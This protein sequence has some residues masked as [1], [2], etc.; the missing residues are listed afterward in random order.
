MYHPINEPNQKKSCL[1]VYIS[2]T[3][4]INLVISIAALAFGIYIGVKNKSVWSNSSFDWNKTL[5]ALLIAG[6]V[7]LLLASI[8]GICGGRKQNKCCIFI[9]QI[10]SI[11]LALFFLVAG[12]I[13]L[14]LTDSHFTDIKDSTCQ[15]KGSN[16]TEIFYYGQEAY[17]SAFSLF[18]T[19]R[20]PCKV[21]N[22]EVKSYI[23]KNYIQMVPFMQDNGSVKVQDCQDYK[24]V[25]SNSD[26]KNQANWLQSLED[27]FDCT[28]MCKKPANIY[29]F[30]DI[31]NGIPDNDTCKEK[32]QDFVQSYGRVAYIV[33]LI[34][35]AY[36]LINAIL[37]FCLCC[38]KKNSGQS[39][40]ERFANY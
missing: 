5:I 15:D 38:R 4:Y 33:G 13:F 23:T 40:Y 8:A 12:F 20:C 28:G 36:L 39:L 29:F 17:N 10:L 31:N 1:Q 3:S 25:F 37:A 18:C 32:F 16:G 11:I 26:V 7:F 14:G 24:T 35:G 9:F 30:S 22:T 6:S 2:W 19:Q 34:V 21:T 27:S